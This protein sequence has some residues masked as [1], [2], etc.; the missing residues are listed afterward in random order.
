M[1]KYEK[2]KEFVENN[3]NAEIENIYQGMLGL[4]KTI[5]SLMNGDGEDP[6]WN[7]P[8][9]MRYFNGAKRYM[10]NNISAYKE[11]C[12]A[13]NKLYNR[14]LTLLNGKYFD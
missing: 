13:W 1:N 6:Y 12:Q 7:G 4:Q 3:V 14:Y 8:Q 5:N 2:A 11:A 9:A 10:D